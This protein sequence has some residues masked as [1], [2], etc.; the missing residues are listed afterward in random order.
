MEDTRR[1]K[2]SKKQLRNQSNETRKYLIA[3]EAE[4]CLYRINF[5]EKK[6]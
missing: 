1:Q 5:E 3:A 4:T 2:L 6:D